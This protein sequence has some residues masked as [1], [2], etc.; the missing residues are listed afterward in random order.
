MWRLWAGFPHVEATV[1]LPAVSP[2]ETQRKVNDS[3]SLSVPYLLLSL[4]LAAVSFGSWHI[5]ALLS[6]QPSRDSFVAYAR[7]PQA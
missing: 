6:W 5:Y 7:W 4:V 2:L 3:T 1:C